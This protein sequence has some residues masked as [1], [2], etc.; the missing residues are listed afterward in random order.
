MTDREMLDTAFAPKI[1]KLKTIWIAWTNSDLT[2]GRGHQLPL[3]ICEKEVSA[4]RLGRKGD[5]MGSDCH[6][7][8]GIA[9]EISGQWYVP[10]RIIPPSKDD[11]AAQ[12]KIDRRA[13]AIE[14]ARAAGLTEDDI[15][16]I[17]RGM[18]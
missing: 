16:E 13:L 11:I 15:A 18:G 12:E 4:R 9:L 14:K 10:G 5:V 17:G 8:K 1:S 2:E 3:A 6:V 7:T